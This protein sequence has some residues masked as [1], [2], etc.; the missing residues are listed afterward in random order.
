MDE[1]TKDW[2]SRALAPGRFDAAAFASTGLG[3]NRVE[4]L[5]RREPRLVTSDKK[6]CEGPTFEKH[7]ASWA[8]AAHKQDLLRPNFTAVFSRGVKSRRPQPLGAWRSST[9]ALAGP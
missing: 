3:R 1:E 2:C 9:A 6:R 4:V 7:T 8:P 5:G